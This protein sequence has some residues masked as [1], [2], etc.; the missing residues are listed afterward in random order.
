[1]DIGEITGSWDC[2]GCFL[3]ATPS[4]LSRPLDDRHDPRYGVLQN[5]ADTR[6]I[7]FEKMD[8]IL[9]AIDAISSDC[10][11]HSRTPPLIAEEY[12]KAETVLT[13]ML[14]QLGL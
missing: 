7:A 5:T 3:G 11:R 9:A 13:Q 1:M 8:D 12:F 10:E 2:K 14:S 4:L 6:G